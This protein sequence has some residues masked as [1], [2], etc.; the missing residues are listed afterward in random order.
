M[1]FVSQD[2]TTKRR[3]DLESQEIEAIW[4]EICPFKSKRSI[5][6]GSIYRPPSSNKADDMSIEAN[7]ER[8]HLLNKETLIVSDINI[9][10]RDKLNW[11]M[12]NI[13][14]QKDFEICILNSL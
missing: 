3:S 1:A 6:L 13:A 11:A 7:I 12:V 5:T 2:S 9:D 4:L 14:L 8:V 10:F